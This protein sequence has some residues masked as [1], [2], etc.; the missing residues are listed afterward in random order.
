MMNVNIK[1]GKVRTE[2]GEVSIA[3][4]LEQIRQIGDFQRLHLISAPK[5]YHKT[6]FLQIPETNSLSNL[7]RIL[8]IEKKKT[9]IP[10]QGWIKK[11]E[12]E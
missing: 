1:I 5:T 8:K 7:E 2:L 6:S 10:Y 9:V 4:H 3:R 11:D 12:E